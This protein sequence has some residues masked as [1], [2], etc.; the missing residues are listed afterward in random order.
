MASHLGRA[1]ALAQNGVASRARPAINR[2]SDEKRL[3]LSKYLREQLDTLTED[4]IPCRPSNQ[5]APLS[6]SQEQ[7]WRH[8][9]ENGAL[10]AFYNESIAIHRHGPIDSAILARS[11]A[12]VTGRHEAWRTTFDL[13]DGQPVQVINPP[14]LTVSLPVNDLRTIPSSN[15]EAEALRI[16][17]EDARTPFDLE[18]GPLMR[19]RLISLSEE[20]H[21]LAVTMHQSITDGVTVN[22]IFPSELITTYEA[23][24]DGRTPVLAELPIQFADYSWWQRQWLRRAPLANELTYWRKRLMPA[25]PELQLPARFSQRTTYRGK[26]YSFSFPSELRQ[27]LKAL[28]REQGVT[29]FTTLLATYSVLLERQ[30][31]QEDFI[32]GTLSPSGR[33][34]SE[35]RDLMGYFLNPVPLRM[36]LSGNPAFREVLLRAREIVSEAIANDDIPLHDLEKEIRP[37]RNS[38]ALFDIVISL[39]PALAELPAGWDQ[40]FMDVESGGARWPL[41]LELSERPNGLAGRA[42]YN[43]DVFSPRTIAHMIEQWRALLEGILSRPEMRL[44]ELSPQTLDE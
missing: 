40:T 25:P 21:R 7:I 32:I 27:R 35:V 37:S 4:S 41:Y 11:L 39:A 13:I 14:P 28:S 2:L 9:R 17:R 38:Q 23:F 26:I 30:T 34:R 12:Q 5:P 8:A 33:K 43:P 1:G 22:K 42:Q 20:E 15:R 24:R 29:L 18:R 3:L 44:A 19:A 16:A 31:G 36:V 10:P 6:L